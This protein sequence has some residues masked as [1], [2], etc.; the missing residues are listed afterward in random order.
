VIFYVCYDPLIYVEDDLSQWRME[1]LWKFQRKIFHP[2]SICWNYSHTHTHTHARTHARTHAHTNQISF[3]ILTNLINQSWKILDGIVIFLHTY[4]S[5]VI[6]LFRNFA[7][8]ATYIL[9]YRYRLPKKIFLMRISKLTRIRF[10][11]F[12]DNF[13]NFINHKQAL[14]HRLSMISGQ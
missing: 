13:K 12:Y 4:H 8:Q 5:Y 10:L 9:N 6:F 1:R 14:S 3:K 2:N 7:S 11:Y